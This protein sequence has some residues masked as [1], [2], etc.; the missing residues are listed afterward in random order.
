MNQYTEKIVFC[1]LNEI[2][3]FIKNYN[4]V[5]LVG[6]YIKPISG[7]QSIS[8]PDGENAK[9]L[10]VLKILWD[11]F[12]RYNIDKNSCVIS[13]GGGTASDVV[14]LAA[15]TYM[16]GIPFASIP[17]TLLAMIDASVGGKRAINSGSAKNLIGSIYQAENIFIDT[18]LLDTLSNEQL[19][20]G[21]SEAIKISLISGFD[22]PVKVKDMILPCIEAK[23][24]IVTQDMYDDKGHRCF[25][26]YGHTI[27]HAL[28]NFSNYKIA[29]GVAIAVGMDFAAKCFCNKSIVKIQNELFEKFGI[30]DN[31]NSSKK[32]LKKDD[33]DDI[34]GAINF[35]KKKNLDKINFVTLEKV[36]KPKLEEIKIDDIKSSLLQYLS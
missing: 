6:N 32:S 21:L 25:L 35:D 3:K 7:V 16:R 28:E 1:K 34:V 4:N 9:T 2:P 26:N 23:Q 19:Q 11:M 8:I 30:L 14:G 15:S 33:V 13:M 24:A 29:H 10:D 5:L 36:G 31:V 22:L 20:N 17:T 18:E 27:G 12:A